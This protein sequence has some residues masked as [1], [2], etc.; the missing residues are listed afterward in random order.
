MILEVAPL[1]AHSFLPSPAP[2]VTEPRHGTASLRPCGGPASRVISISR[3]S[4]VIPPVTPYPGAPE[5]A[6]GYA[7]MLDAAARAVRS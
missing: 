4:R 6:C 5:V 1:L 2:H 3:D 7:A